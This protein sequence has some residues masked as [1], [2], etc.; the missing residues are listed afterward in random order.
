[1][2]LRPYRIDEIQNKDTS[3]LRNSIKQL[4]CPLFFIS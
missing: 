1:M 4:C 3:F 2:A